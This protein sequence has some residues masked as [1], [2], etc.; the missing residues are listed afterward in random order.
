MLRVK[1]P[2]FPYWH[3]PGKCWY[4][5][6]S[7]VYI[8]VCKSIY[9]YRLVYISMVYTRIHVFHPS[10][11]KYIMAWRSTV[12]HHHADIPLHFIMYSVQTAPYVFQMCIYSD[13]LWCTGQHE[14]FCWLCMPWPQP[15]QTKQDWN[16]AGS[17]APFDCARRTSILS[18]LKLVGVRISDGPPGP[19][20]AAHKAGWVDWGEHA[21]CR[22]SR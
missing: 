13:I 14:M 18:K 10:I 1:S 12:I 9:L 15:S 19:A 5:L 7:S 21:G 11:Q 22:Q 16:S 6:K 8:L 20:L 4:I 17:C 2:G 3:T